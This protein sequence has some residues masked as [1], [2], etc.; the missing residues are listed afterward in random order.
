MAVWLQDGEVLEADT[1]AGG[2]STPTVIGTTTGA[3]VDSAPQVAFDTSGDA[4]AAWVHYDGTD[5]SVQA[6]SLA[7]GTSTWTAL[8]N[9]PAPSA[10]AP[11]DLQ[12]AEESPGPNS[13]QNGAL[14]LGW[15]SGSAPVFEYLGS[16]TSSFASV[17]APA[18][19]SA[20]ANSLSVAMDGE[21]NATAV[22]IDGGTSDA[23]VADITSSSLGRA[24]PTFG[25]ATALSSS[26]SSDPMV[27]DDSNSA[28]NSGAGDT[29]VIWLAGADA[30]AA[31]RPG[32]GATFGSSQNLGPADA[33][34]PRIAL[35]STADA[36]AVWTQ[37]GATVGAAA[38]LS[39]ATTFPAS[40]TVLSAA[41]HTTTAPLLAVDGAGNGAAGWLDSTATPAA[42]DVAGFDGTGPANTDL[43]IPEGGP[44]EPVSAVLGRG[45]TLY[46]DPTDVWPAITA[47]SWNFGDGHTATGG[48]VTHAYANPGDYTVTVTSTASDGTTATSTG[49]VSIAGSAPTVPIGAL[50]QLPSPNDCVSSTLIGCGT[51]DAFGTNLA[52]QAIL[53]PDSRNVYLVGF[54]GGIVEF[55]R[56]T[57]TG[58]LTQI[59]CLSSNP[60]GEPSCASDP[61]LGDELGNPAALAIS[62]DGRSAYAVAQSS[63][64]IVTF[65][66]D[67]STGQ[68]TEVAGD[69]Y[70]GAPTSSTCTNTPGL[71][72]GNYG[73]AVSPDGKNVYVSNFAGYGAGDVAEF[74]RNTS[75]G[76]IAPLAGN[77]CISD[78][79]V[80]GCPVQ[81]AIGL[82]QA[83]GIAISPDGNDLYVEAG[84]TSLSHDIAE[85]SRDPSTGAL[86][87]IPGNACI[88]SSS[89]PAG[90]VTTATAFNGSEDMAISPNGDFA[91]ANSF[92]DDAVVGFSR[93]PTTGAL[94]QVG[95]VESSSGP[96]G[97][98]CE[99]ATGITGP[100]GVAVS[101]DGTNL[102]V[103]GAGDNAEASFSIDTATGALTQLATPFNCIT[104]NA[105]AP[106]SC[107][108]SDGTG[109]DG[110]RRV[111]VSSDGTSVYAAG[112]G[113]QSIVELARTPVPSAPHADEAGYDLD[114]P[115][116]SASTTFT[117]PAVSCGSNPSGRTAGQ[118]IGVRLVG[119]DSSAGTL[120]YP[121]ASAEVRTYCVGARAQYGTEFITDAINHGTVVYGA[122]N[123]VTVAPGD[124]VTLS[125]AAS[126]GGTSLTIADLDTGASATVSGPGF[127]AY[128]GASV[129]VGAIAGDGH[130]NPLVNA[131]PPAG[132]AVTPNPLPGPVPSA[133]VAFQ[134]TA[135]DGASLSGSSG[136]RTS[137]WSAA[138][139]TLASVGA[140]ATPGDFAAD[141]GSAA[142]P[143]R[144]AQTAT[145]TP[146]S[147]TVTVRLPRG[148]R[149]VSLTAV[150]S[151]PIDSILNATHGSVQITVATPSGEQ[152]GV[153]FDGEFILRQSRSGRLTAVLTG[154][155]FAGCPKPKPHRALDASQASTGKHKPKKVRQLWANAHG[156]FTTQGQ[157]GSAAVSGTEW[158]TADEC[159]GTYFFVKRH[160]I[161]VTAFHLHDRKVPLSQGHSFLAPA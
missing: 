3:A 35:N 14:L 88:G 21:G 36:L 109:L 33:V 26:A 94:A 83:I 51:L 125:V 92:G 118:A 67:P 128:E 20:A 23:E 111:A 117:I 154:G 10:T 137:A 123:P 17:S 150:T 103:S 84:G 27:A 86:R 151:I 78:G 76:A 55:S 7:S 75:T 147:G 96:S 93:N 25:A 72:A 40:P 52:Y 122:P 69:C 160:A 100:L 149:F 68:L 144:L 142:A 31:V 63:Q 58:A 132:A 56:D 50:A 45:L 114:A 4:V 159:A 49:T 139:A 19:A 8:T 116:S 135:I 2:W 85:L 13:S 79:S 155:S 57:A 90:C 39:T 70:T 65:S 140:L 138:G 120:A 121:A 24:S 129:Y 47:I 136:V 66:R 30:Y 80:P 110:P 53:S 95:C 105:G 1:L 134:S 61:F 48:D 112:Q 16:G 107:G 127:S 101:P 34:Q 97:L 91:W 44:S 82:Q 62:P 158:L 28:I 145:A 108:Q 102:Y 38:P 41:G 115:A 131:S 43:L 133:P 130:G 124:L 9:L 5:Y 87:P 81:S 156:S 15:Q 46:V 59:G 73:V 22:W 18:G 143:P 99:P 119:V 64:S 71:G 42:A 104:A 153:F 37:G 77:S 29:A 106:P 89:A 98:D 146:V 32:S 60:I 141:I 161:L 11:T 113:S 54:F 152:S 74:A 157:D 126:T 148:R 6:T 12:I